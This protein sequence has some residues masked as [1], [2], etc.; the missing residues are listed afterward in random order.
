[1]YSTKTAKTGILKQLLDQLDDYSI[2]MHYMGKFKVGKLYNS[3]LRND[4]K[5]P[6]FAVF[7]G[8]RGDL[9]FK[10]HGSG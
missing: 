4:D 5:N 6:S 3:P 9:M 1:M 2:Y 7:K 10:D 8:S